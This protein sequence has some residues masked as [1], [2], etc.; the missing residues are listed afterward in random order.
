MLPKNLLPI[1]AKHRTT[2][3]YGAVWMPDQAKRA[4]ILF[5]HAAH[6]IIA[7]NALLSCWYAFIC[8]G[9]VGVKLGKR[10]PTKPRRKNARHK[11]VL[12]H[13]ACRQAQQACFPLL[14]TKQ[15]ASRAS[16][17]AKH[18]WQH[19]LAGR[20]VA[21][22][23]FLVRQTRRVFAECVSKRVRW[24]NQ[25]PRLHFFVR[26]VAT[27]DHLQVGLRQARGLHTYHGDE[28]LFL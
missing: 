24:A 20:R 16:L 22:T 4:N 25:G 12:W 19:G 17:C 1:L 18:K 6:R 7:P 5:D 2:D 15:Q 9:S 13:S 11:R 27:K 10:K 3:L 14:P 8:R 26:L 23:S 21:Q 28:P